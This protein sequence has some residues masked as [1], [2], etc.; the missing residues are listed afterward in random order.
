MRDCYFNKM[1]SKQ[2]FLTASL[3]LIGILL[4][5]SERNRGVT[6]EQ[7]NSPESTWSAQWIWPPAIDIEDPLTEG[8]QWI[9]YT[10]KL[11]TWA[12]SR[13]LPDA[14]FVRNFEIGRA[15][16]IRK[17]RFRMLV[18]DQFTLYI[19]GQMVTR[20]DGSKP[21]ADLEVR[22]R[23]LPGWN[24][25]T[26]AAV[27]RGVRATPVRLAAELLFE[28]D[29]GQ[30]TV[31]ATDREWKAGRR[32]PFDPS[33]Y[34]ATRPM[35]FSDKRW[36][37]AI[38]AGKVTRSDLDSVEKA[39]KN[40]WVCFRNTVNLERKPGRAVAKIGVD[41]KY[42][43]WVNDR[44]VVFEGGLKRGPT[45]KDGYYDE[46]DIAPY[47]SEGRNT[48]AILVWYWGRHGFGHIDSGRPGLVFEADLDG[49]R[50][51][52]D[53]TWKAMRHPSYGPSSP[54][55]PNYRFAEFNV[56]FDARQEISGWQRPDFDD[57]GW[58]SVEAFGRPPVAPWNKLWKRP[59][60][61]WRDSGLI[62]YVNKADLPSRSNGEVINA[63]LPYNAMVTAYLKINSPAGLLIGIQT[64]NYMGGRNPNVRA[65][66][67][68]REGTQE[69]EAL[70]FSNGH[71]VQY[72]IPSGVE[73]IDL[74]YRETRY[75]TDWTGSFSSS[76]PFFDTL[77]QKSLITMNV[78]M[79]DNFADCPDRE[80]A[81]WWGDASLTLG[82][83]FYT[84]DPRAYGLIRKAISNLVEFQRPDKTLFSPVPTGIWED[85]LPAQMLAAVG[86]YG[87][88][89]YYF[90]SGDAE[91][92]RNVYPHVRDYLSLWKIGEDG[93]VVHRRGDWD[94]G[95][96]GDHIDAPLLDNTWYYLALKAAVEMARVSG[97]E[98]D[99]AVYRSQME[100][101]RRNF[102]A[103]F[104]RGNEYRS[105][106][107][108]GETD[109][110]GNAMAVIA[111]FA[112]KAKW[113]ALKRVLEKE[114]HASP[115]MEKYILEAFFKMSEPEA[116][117]QRM[118]KRYSEMVASPLTTLWEHW[119]IT[120]GTYNHSWSGGP[121]TLLSQYVAGVAPE[122]P[123]WGRFHV[124]PQLG[125][126]TSVKAVVPTIRGN[127]VVSHRRE[128]SAFYMDVVYPKGTTAVIGIPGAY[129]KGKVFVNGKD[130][131]REAAKAA[132]KSKELLL[133]LF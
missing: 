10:T 66:Y 38:D 52:S 114:F 41:S 70:A 100:S 2:R 75:D 7:A 27:R 26:V 4:V 91:V 36:I 119:D 15:S 123:G 129:L 11:N 101:I 112:D 43:L 113:P 14:Y 37:T 131:S 103:A 17:A 81:Q 45:P 133:H 82:Q 60:P 105:A 28:L 53:Q 121:L 50:I 18:D 73:I 6:R 78:N 64:D 116:G 54:P 128:A 32:L 77:W 98:K 55:Y 42:W 30:K 110:R 35:D 5:A 9:G 31:I 57:S 132:K 126:L 46:L 67:V 95:D 3:V 72:S 124:F 93:L 34:D 122:T 99:A 106:G 68:T 51:L 1:I 85:E 118:K 24:T 12:F 84:C 115:Y 65:E 40:Q 88:W 127:I 23:L 47:L 111:G 44:L 39:K 29:N 21:Y 117:L 63:K 130:V 96:W 16:A 79:R 90:Y 59:I 108:R 33:K 71:A 69:F 20:D 80:R 86:W 104:W 58:S 107:Y 102:N 19:N 87:F 49:S 94:W 76:N 25:I 56:H 89:T 74:K 125:E 109:D 61:L 97:H 120:Q 8:S 62:D 92:I 22:T 48:V 83:V 13:N